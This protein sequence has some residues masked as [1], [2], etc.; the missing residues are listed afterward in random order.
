M[1]RLILLLVAVLSISCDNELKLEQKQFSAASKGADANKGARVE[2][3][4]P[5]AS[6][7]PLVADSINRKIL[8]VMKDIINYGETPFTSKNYQ[9]LANDFI[10]TYEKVS[11]EFPDDKM[12]WEA[13]VTGRFCYESDVLLNLEIDHYTFTGGAHGYSGKSSL[14]FDPAS[15]KS[16]SEKDLITNPSEFLKIAEIAFRKKYKIANTTPLNE[17]GFMFETERFQLPQTYF[18]TKDGLLLYY[19]VYEIA[20]YAQGPQ[21]VLISYEEAKPFI[22]IPF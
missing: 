5:V 2:I 8:S 21:E 12:A 18:F 4:L 14:L 13:K 6:N 10:S 22:A 3:S 20:S 1:N 16:I 17:A 15:G 11:A 7:K 9:E 19:N